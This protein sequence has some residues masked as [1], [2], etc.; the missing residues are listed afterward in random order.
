MY[1][2][3]ELSDHTLK[4]DGQHRSRNRFTFRFSG[5]IVLSLPGS[6]PDSSAFLER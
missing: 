2:L 3:A 1:R 5:D 4:E 6:Q